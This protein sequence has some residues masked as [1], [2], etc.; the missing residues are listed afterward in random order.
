MNFNAKED[1]S[2]IMEKKEDPQQE[3]RLDPKDKVTKTFEELHAPISRTLDETK[4]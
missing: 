3:A 4:I 1:T 2:E